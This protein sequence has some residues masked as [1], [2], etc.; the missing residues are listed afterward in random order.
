MK[1]LLRRLG[2][3]LIDLLTSKKAIAAGLGALAGLVVKDP[4]VRAHVVEVLMVYIG[5]QGL[6]DHAKATAEKKLGVDG[7]KPLPV[8][9][10][11]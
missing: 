2:V 5:S 10:T 8:A 6:V 11:P 1:D 4:A 9:V 7:A 3:T